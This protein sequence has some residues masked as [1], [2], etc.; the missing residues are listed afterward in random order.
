[1]KTSKQISLDDTD[2]QILE[3]LQRNCKQ[4]I[5]ELAERVLLSVSA[6]H[7][8]IK[9]LED[10][11]II[12]GYVAKLSAQQLGYRVEFFVELSLASQGEEAFKKFEKAVLLIPEVLECYLVG[13]QYDYLLRIVASDTEDYERIHRESISRLPGVT[14]IQSILSL[15]TVKSNFGLPIR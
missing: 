15:R 4:S 1:M 5:A 8:R 3:Q 12:T 11:G 13:G 2:L 14:R 7:R 10:A 9:T 6:C